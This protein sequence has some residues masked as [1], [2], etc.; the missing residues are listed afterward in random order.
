MRNL[1]TVSILHYV[2]GGLI[3]LT[4]I[5]LGFAMYAVGGMLNSDLMQHEMDAPPEIV[6]HLMQ[7]IGSGVAFAVL[8]FGV[9]VMLSGYWISKARNRTG[10]M[11]IAALCCLSIPFGTALGVFTLITLSNDEVK[12][13]YSGIL[14]R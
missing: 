6:G 5:F 14:A 4:A 9:F 12:Q 1:S 7:S 3:C 10:S 2:Y 8:A 13:H 11:V